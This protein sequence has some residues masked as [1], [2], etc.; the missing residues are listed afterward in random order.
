MK[1]STMKGIP[2]AIS[3]LAVSP[4]CAHWG[5]WGDM[6]PGHMRTDERTAQADQGP[7][8]AEATP[9]TLPKGQGDQDQMR[10]LLDMMGM[11]RE[12]MEGMKGMSVDPITQHKMDEMMKRMEDLMKQHR[13][14]M[15]E[16]G[17]SP[18]PVLH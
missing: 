16:R 1:I 10:M 9:T 14:M 8:M 12:M 13:A 11:M 7:M 4:A 17:M 15:T 2:F 18:P 5:G 6:Q 3:L